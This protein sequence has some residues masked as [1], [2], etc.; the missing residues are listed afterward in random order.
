MFNA[1]RPLLA[2]IETAML[3]HGLTPTRFGQMA[4]QDGNFISRLK[5][6]ARPHQATIIRV[7]SFLAL[8]DGS[9]LPVRRQAIE[10]AIEALVGLL[11]AFQPDPD[12]EEVGLEDSFEDHRGKAMTHGPGCPVADIDHGAEEA[13]EQRSY[14][15]WDTLSS[16]LRRAGQIDGKVIDPNGPGVDE[17]AEDD[18]RDSC[19]AADDDPKRHVS[20]G[21]PGDAGDAED[22]G[23]TELNGDEGDYTEGD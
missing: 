8:L 7:R 17:E 2:E 20:D 11:D 1:G 18:D 14:A 21:R 16:N 13:G 9:R 19:L 10:N 6:G 12:L 15:E 3:R 23:D 5:G 22:G 4:V